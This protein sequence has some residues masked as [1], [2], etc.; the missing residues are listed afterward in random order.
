MMDLVSATSL[1]DALHSAFLYQF[2]FAIVGGV[3]LSI[4]N[5]FSV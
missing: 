1:N 4:V 2:I 5:R 3:A